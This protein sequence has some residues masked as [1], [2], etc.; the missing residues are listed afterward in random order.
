MTITH[1]IV[2]ELKFSVESFWNEEGGM[3]HDTF[4]KPVD[5]IEE[6]LFNLQLA[7]RQPNQTDFESSN[8]VIVATEVKQGTKKR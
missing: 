8:W 4:G 6:A 3:G 1:S 2:T 7:Q 5:T